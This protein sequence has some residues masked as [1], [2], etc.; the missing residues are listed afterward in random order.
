M[1]QKSGLDPVFKDE[2]NP[3]LLFNEW[4][5]DAEQSEINDPNAFNLATVDSFGQPD[6]R[7]LLL[8][9]QTDRGFIFYTNLKSK[10]GRDLKSNP[11]ASMC[12]H[13]KSLQRQIRIQGPVELVDKKIADSYFASRPYESRI[14]AWASSQSEVMKH[15]DEFEDKVKKF[16][17]QYADPNNVPRPEHWSGWHLT[18]F[19]IEFW[20]D[21]QNRLHQRLRYS[22]IEKSWDREILYP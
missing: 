2:K 10:K 17:K 18:P 19:K 21:V 11:K 9:G 3:F 20:K 1:N 6:N 15:R 7:V 22:L 16:K 12:F 13:W 14:G 8:K 5:K 4:M